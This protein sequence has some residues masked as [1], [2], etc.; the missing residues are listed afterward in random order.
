MKFEELKIDHDILK[1]INEMKFEE[2]TEIQE[3]AIPLIRNNFDVIGE[4]ATGS[5]KTLVFSIQIVEQNIKS[6]GVQSLV[7]VPTRELCEQISK[8]IKKFSKYKGLTVAS[9]HGGVSYEP[10]NDILEKAEIVVGTPG[11][12]LD[13]IR[14]GSFETHKI[15]V[16]VIDEV[17]RMLDMGF[18][19]DVTEIERNISPKRQ[20][21][22]FSATV[23]SDIEYLARKFMKNPKIVSVENYVDPSLLKQY[24][25][26]ASNGNKFSLLVHLLRNDKTDLVM[27]FCNTRRNVDF[28]SRNL[29]KQG[30]DAH[31]M[32]G[33]LTQSRRNKIIDMFRSK[34]V[35]ILIASDVAARGLDIK[36]ISHV[37]NYDMPKTEDEYIHRIGR[38]ARAGN[39]G[40]AISIISERD[41][42]NF[43]R[44][45]RDENISMQRLEAPN[46]ER[47]NFIV[48]KQDRQFGNKQWR[49]RR[50]EDKPHHPR[51][52]S[53]RAIN[54]S[55]VKFKNS[56]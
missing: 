54:S 32:H 42:D 55:R 38:T 30:I 24:Y 52:F 21:L 31:P 20:T 17:D 3:K 34:E 4:S 41:Y 43:Y 6:E 35:K 39:E 18:I 16:F 49:N 22:L 33:G 37:Y 28:L 2:P 46:F 15:K 29:R 48:Y 40:Q 47:I 12:I 56:K 1:V 50:Y 36:N 27:V 10:Q 25:Y 5:G 51:R 44:I 11:R 13:H 8:E 26:K 9:I 19:R 14:R 7:L 23:D 45:T 53:F